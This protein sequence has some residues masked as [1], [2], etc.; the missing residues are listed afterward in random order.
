MEQELFVTFLSF[1]LSVALVLV[2]FLICLLTRLLARSLSHSIAF[3]PLPIT[4]RDDND[5]LRYG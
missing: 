1:A 4:E 5:I 3:G 2:F